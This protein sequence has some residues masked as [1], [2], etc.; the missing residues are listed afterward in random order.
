MQLETSMA[1]DKFI[2]KPP[3]R[4]TTHGDDHTLINIGIT[5]TH[6]AGH[7][8]ILLNMQEIPCSI[9]AQDAPVPAVFPTV[10]GVQG[11]KSPHQ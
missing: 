2:Q 4:T 9:Q 7:G 10:C 5:A 6:N 1:L 11:R 8:N 3:L